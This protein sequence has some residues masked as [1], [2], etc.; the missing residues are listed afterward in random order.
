MIIDIYLLKLCLQGD[1]LMTLQMQKKC[2]SEVLLNNIDNHNIIL[3]QLI[4]SDCLN[5]ILPK[6]SNL[7]NYS[8]DSLLLIL[9]KFVTNFYN[10]F[11]TIGNHI[12]LGLEYILKNNNDNWACQV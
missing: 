5:E 11:P 6:L 2:L 10:T 3:Y 4:Q 1:K 12:D 8:N 7:E 9:D